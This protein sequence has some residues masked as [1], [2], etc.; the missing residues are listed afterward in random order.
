MLQVSEQADAE[1]GGQEKDAVPDVLLSW[2]DGQHEPPF[3]VSSLSVPFL[4]QSLSARIPCEAAERQAV[5]RWRR[6]T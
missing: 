1:N 4:W 3:S 2:K 6:R 5:Q